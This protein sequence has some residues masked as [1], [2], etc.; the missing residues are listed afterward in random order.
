MVTLYNFG[1]LRGQV[2][3]GG[4]AQFLTANCRCTPATRQVPILQRH[5]HFNTMGFYVQDDWRVTPRLTLNLGMR[6]EPT[7]TYD[8]NQWN[9]SEHTKLSDRCNLRR[10]GRRSGIR[11]SGTSARGS[12]LPGM[13]LETGVRRFGVVLRCSM[14]WRH[15][16]AAVTTATYN[17]ARR[18]IKPLW[19]RSGTFTIPTVIPP[20]TLSTCFAGRCITQRSLTDLHVQ[21]DGGAAVARFDGLDGGLCRI[22]R[23]QSPARQGRQSGRS[24]RHP[25]GWICVKPP[26]GYDHQ[27]GKQIDGQATSCYLATGPQ[28]RNPNWAQV[29]YYPGRR[30]FHL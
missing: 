7:T 15:L 13:S 26:G 25:F 24:Q 5:F 1:S 30:G 14:T 16:G 20:G 23:Y 9:L 19:S 4:V 3:F 2:T 10:S 8:R 27:Y 22:T 28:R 12:G 6:Y 21:P 11:R 29:T 17:H 18:S